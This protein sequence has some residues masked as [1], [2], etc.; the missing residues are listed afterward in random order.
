[1]KITSVP[2]VAASDVVVEVAPVAP[3]AGAIVTC[4]ATP[5]CVSGMPAD[6]GTAVIGE[7]PGTTSNVDAGLGERQRL[8]AAAPE[9]ERVAALQAHDVE[10]CAAERRR[11]AR[12]SRSCVEAVARDPQRVCRRLVDELGGDEAVVDERVAGAD[13]LE[14]AHGDQAGVAG[15]GADERDGHP[16]ASATSSWK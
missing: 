12:S 2:G 6:A 8:L 9:D 4:A 14:A 7:T 15:A 11:A 3:R 16:S 5:R 1:M 13:E 10:P